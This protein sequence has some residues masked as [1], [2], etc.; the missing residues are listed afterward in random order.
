VSLAFPILEDVKN[1]WEWPQPPF[2]WHHVAADGDIE[3]PCRIE[4]T[5]GS[6]VD[7]FMWRLEP[8]SARL[9][10]RSRQMSDPGRLAFTQFRRLTLT[11]P[12]TCAP[13]LHDAPSQVLPAAAQVRE[14]RLER[15][16]GEPAIA[17]RTAGHVVAD[18]G[19]YL[20]EP[21]EDE[22]SLIRVFVPRSAYSHCEFGLTAREIAARSRIRSPEQ[23]LAAIEGQHRM[24]VLRMGQSLLDLGLITCGQ[25]ENALS[26]SSDDVPLGERL[27]AMRLISHADL[28]TAI[29]HKL[30]YPLVDLDTFP[31]EP[32]AASLV[33]PNLAIRCRMLA[34]MTVGRRL[35]V[36]VDRP[37]RVDDVQVL[38]AF[39]GLEL[40][41][42][43]AL[44]DEIL[45][46]LRRVMQRDGR[47]EFGSLHPPYFATTV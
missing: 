22:R 23:L 41:P 14:Y 34:L 12:L 39:S 8:A 11:C 7:G 19:L 27:M 24:P 26:R 21:T 31:I 20:F 42:V 17:G 5:R 30:G 16:S 44:E 33:H 35:I 25:L 2:S 36:A 43:L 32:A 46:A 40:V 29:A 45:R 13:E 37:Q 18:E 10:F 3:Q 28:Q 4:T 6:A 38:T 47:S 9:I 1:P 15:E